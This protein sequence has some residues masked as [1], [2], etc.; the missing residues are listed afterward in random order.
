MTISYTLQPIPFWYFSDLVG[1]PLAGGT[2]YSYSSLNPTQF[3]PIFQDAAGINEWT[4]PI[5]FD[6]TGTIG[7]LFFQLDTSNPDDLY[8]L[9][10]FDANGNLVRQINQYPISGGSGGG[11]V[12]TV[13]NIDNIIVNG[14]F[15]YNIGATT[16]Q[17]IVDQTFLCS[18]AH[19]GLY[20]PDINFIKGV[21]SSATDVVT[22]SSFGVGSNPISPDF[23]PAY[24]MNYTCTNNPVGE[25]YKGIRIPIAPFV[26]TIANQI[27]TFTIQARSN[28]VGANNIILQLRQYFG[29]GGTPSADQ[30]TTLSTL[31]LTNSFALYSVSFTVTPISGK[32]LGNSNDDGTY[33]E[34]LIPTNQ[35]CNIDIA[36]PSLYASSIFPTT[37]YESIDK[38]ESQLQTPRTG[39]VRQSINEFSN[40]MPQSGWISLND[41][42]IGNSSSNATCRANSDTWLLYR[43]LWNNTFAVYNSSGVPISKGGTALSDWNSNNQVQLPLTQGRVIAARGDGNTTSQSYTTNASNQIIV[44][45]TS[46]FYTGCPFILTSGAPPPLSN[47]ITYYANVV[48]S[49]SIKVYTSAEAAIANGPNNILFPNGASGTINNPPIYNLQRFQGENVH[50]QLESE[51]AAH[52]HPGSTV[53]ILRRNNTGGG[54]I[55]GYSPLGGNGSDN[56]PL[57]MA[58]D[59]SSIPFNVVQPTVFYNSIIKL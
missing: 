40:T 18:G 34:I 19:T 13:Q 9:Q 50:Q 52:F 46:S 17:P 45:S 48:N 43:K 2:L 31:T 33:L 24:F 44:G 36:K 26:N 57:N 28:G 42:T 58:Q 59:G 51:L 21:T 56:L 14:S 22:F 5:L 35:Q 7:P 27:M 16:A 37:F 39:D 47:N 6:E 11:T 4:N 55:A 1:K 20:Y 15:I 38:I 53:T 3:K 25:T 32:T 23:A 10:I 29:T 54:T 8:F 49:T 41:K 30:L 12:N